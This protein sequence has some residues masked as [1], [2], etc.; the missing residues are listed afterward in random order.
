MAILN[1]YIKNIK[2][3]YPHTSFPL[4]PIASD[5]TLVNYCYD[6][7]Y[8]N[9]CLCSPIPYQIHN[10]FPTIVKV[11]YCDFVYNKSDVNNMS[12]QIM[13]HQS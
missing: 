7:S 4:Y 10:F 8:C 2:K 9:S 3:P 11:V 1:P 12:K 13:L 5:K 6:V